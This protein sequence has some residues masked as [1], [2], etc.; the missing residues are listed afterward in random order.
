MFRRRHRDSTLLVIIRTSHENC[1]LLKENAIVR[2]VIGIAFVIL[3]Y[4]YNVVLVWV[5]HGEVFRAFLFC[6]FPN[7]VGRRR[8]Q[9]ARPAYVRLESF[10][11]DHY[12]CKFEIPHAN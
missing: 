9:V 10:W 5:G 3:F 1:G 11:Y 8:K 6:D 2:V 4:I 12:D 7:I